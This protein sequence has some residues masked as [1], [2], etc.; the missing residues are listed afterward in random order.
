MVIV[1]MCSS[2]VGSGCVDSVRTHILVHTVY[3]LS[4]LAFF[5]SLDKTVGC[6][7]RVT[8]IRGKRMAVMAWGNSRAVPW[9]LTR[10]SGSYIGRAR[11]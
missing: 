5:F 6:S 9:R 10:G 4:P 8:D 2:V 7:A 11:H 1:V 3:E